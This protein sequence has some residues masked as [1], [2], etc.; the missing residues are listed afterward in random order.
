MNLAHALAACGNHDAALQWMRHAHATDPQ[1]P[2]LEMNL[3]AI[4]HGRGELDEAASH[5]A[6]A[7][8]RRPDYAEAW[9]NHGN[10]ALYAGDAAAAVT[11]FDRA[12]HS[13]KQLDRALA[14]IVYALNYVPD[15]TPAAIRERAQ[16]W[17][18]RFALPRCAPGP[19]FADRRP[20]R[21]L[22]IG[23]VSPDLANHPIGHF[24]IGVLA[25]HARDRFEAVVYSERA[26]EDEMSATMKETATSWC[27]TPG[28]SDAALIERIVSDRIDI[29]VDLAGHTSGNRL[30]VFT[31][32]PAPVQLTWMGSVGTTGL[33][34]MDGVIADRFHV[35]PGQ[36]GSYVEQV[37]RLPE[38]FVCF[39]P[40]AYAPAVGEAPFQRNG[41]ITFGCFSNPAK[42][43]AS[44]MRSWAAILQRIPDAR[45]RL[46]YRWM[47]ARA[48]RQRIEGVFERHG[49]ESERLIIEG[50]LPHRGLLGAYGGIDIALDTWPYSGCATTLEALWMGCPVIT[51]PE[52]RFASRHTYSVLATL[53]LDD[54]IASDAAAYVEA[55][56]RL[57]TD[58]AT[59]GNLRSALRDRLANS[60]LCD[61]AGFTKS[62][63]AVYRE[64]WSSRPKSSG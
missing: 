40:P 64:A 25:H 9:L 42:I 6:R 44:L 53:G 14:N 11:R 37:F 32:K 61:P 47:D 38:S 12:L 10:A 35:P 54:L 1:N 50:E 43:N 15:A 13:N 39:E 21:K 31:A 2:V 34:A 63:E 22:R 56:A 46:R 16:D 17:D 26:V 28:L 4:H 55:A 29:L 20:D 45:L 59:L 36:E 58:R 52:Q 57:A 49:I 19:A 23:Y 30:R 18:R 27:R 60:P 41:F 7:I 48:N 5:Y 3:G 24:M 51:R 62:L 8:E 33:A